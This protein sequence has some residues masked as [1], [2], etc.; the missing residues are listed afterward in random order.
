MIPQTTI[1]DPER[2][3]I[4]RATAL[5]CIV[6]FLG[7]G[8]RLDAWIEYIRGLLD[9]ARRGDPDAIKH[10]RATLLEV[11]ADFRRQ[12]ESPADDVPR[13][14]EDGADD[15]RRR[16]RFVLDR[17]IAELPDEQPEEQIEASRDISN[18]FLLVAGLRSIAGVLCLPPSARL[19]A[20]P[21]TGNIIEAAVDSPILDEPM[22]HVIGLCLMSS[23]ESRAVADEMRGLE[24]VVFAFDQ[25]AAECQRRLEAVRNA[26]A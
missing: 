10:S 22:A 25:L 24:A 21:S 13:D 26:T 16:M 15:F 5:L 6:L 4:L 1:T 19:F 9:A 20:G 7:A 3:S 2:L 11:F 8:L 14:G 12:A 23:A 18:L 17:A